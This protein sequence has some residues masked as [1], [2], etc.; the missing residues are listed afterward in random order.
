VSP[1]WFQFKALNGQLTPNLHDPLEIEAFSNVIHYGDSMRELCEQSM[2]AF[3]KLKS[4]NFHTYN[5]DPLSLQYQLPKLD[6]LVMFATSQITPSYSMVAL[7]KLLTDINPKL[8]LVLIDQDLSHGSI[9]SKIRKWKSQAPDLKIHVIHDNFK[10]DKSVDIVSSQSHM[11]FP[12]IDSFERE[13]L[14]YGYKPE[15]AYIGNDYDRREVMQLFFQGPEVHWYG[16]KKKDFDEECPTNCIHHGPFKWEVPIEDKYREHTFGI[17]ISRE[18]YYKRRQYSPRFLEITQ[19]GV[20]FFSHSKYANAASFTTEFFVV[21]GYSDLFQKLHIACQSDSFCADTAAYQR[22]AIKSIFS[23]ERWLDT[24]GTVINGAY[25][26][27]EGFSI[28]HY[29]GIL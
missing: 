2:D 26:Q 24:I 7:L 3:T 28:N 5:F 27:M 1:H 23:P 4:A 16:R 19:S 21:D 20:P 12:Y 25:H 29:E 18:K 8:S 22:Q 6:V 14:T 15:V 10:K 11:A 17:N 9:T 13:I